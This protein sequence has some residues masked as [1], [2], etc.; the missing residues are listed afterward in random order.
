MKARLLFISGSK[1]GTEFELGDT[2]VTIGRESDQDI[3]FLPTE[4]LVSARHATILY[5]DGRYVLKDAGSKNGTFVNDKKVT[6]HELKPGDVIAFGPGGPSAGFAAKGQPELLPTLD[7]AGQ[8]TEV[9][10]LSRSRATARPG[11]ESGLRRAVTVTREVMAMAVERSSRRARRTVIWAAAISITAIFGLLIVQERNKAKLQQALGDLAT[12]LQ[13]ERFSRSILEQD[14]ASIETRYDSL[15]IIVERE[16]QLASTGNRFGP[17]VTRNFS[18][19]VA[20]IVSSYGYVNRATKQQLRFRVDQRGRPIT[21]V[22]GDGSRVPMVTFG[23]K[24][25]Q[26]IQQGSATGFLID[27]AGWILTNR[28]VAEPWS[29]DPQLELMRSRGLDVE[30]RL[31]VLRAYFPPG[32]RS[33]SLIVQKLADNADVALLKTLRTIRAPAL[34]LADEQAA[35]QPGEQVVYIGYPTGVHNLLFRVQNSDREDILRSVGDDH[36][37]L[38]EEL[39]RRKLIQPLATTGSVSDTTSLEIIHTAATTGGG[40]G[41]PLIDS[42]QRVIAIHYAQLLSPVTGD[43]FRTQRAVRVRYAWDLLPTDVQRAT[44]RRR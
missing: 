36:F 4:V 38:V 24:G 39:A 5:K 42:R 12:A 35:V 9:L 19:G 6:E 30:P 8:T 21:T 11:G 13:S 34:P 44:Q 43:P 27:T 17:T 23:G 26:V 32:D 37:R 18:R 14:L 2:D 29:D 25:P 28:H 33:D 16:R 40:S 20:L 10:A 3:V 1:T 15:Q 22:A 7:V 31:T 41:G